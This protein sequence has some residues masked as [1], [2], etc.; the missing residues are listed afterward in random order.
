MGGCH[1]NWVRSSGR[2]ACFFVRTVRELRKTLESQRSSVT[3]Y[4]SRFYRS[5]TAR[6]GAGVAGCLLLAYL[7]SGDSEP[8]NLNMNLSKLAATQLKSVATG[9]VSK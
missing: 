9:E 5:R 1:A 6:Y 2:F 3:C 7:L 4:I 8:D